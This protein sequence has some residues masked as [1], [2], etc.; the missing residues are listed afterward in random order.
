MV[1]IATAYKVPTALISGGPSWI[2]SEAFDVEARSDAAAGEDQIKL[3]L[4]TLL[5]N[6]FR[7]ALHRETKDM[8]IS[9]MT[10]GKRS[11]K[12][13]TPSDDEMPSIRWTPSA[14]TGQKVSMSALAVF[15]SRVV[16]HT[17]IDK[18]GI[19]GGESPLKQS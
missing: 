11:P 17:V 5:A 15:L 14:V 12:F 8:P 16:G 7:L 18:T 4:Q 1:L 10:I 6:R 2:G 9:L 13:T 19:E 3:M